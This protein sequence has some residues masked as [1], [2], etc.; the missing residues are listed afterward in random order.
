[1]AR[2][3]TTELLAPIEI[4]GVWHLRNYFI[5]AEAAEVIDLD[6][7]SM[8]LRRLVSQIEQHHLSVE[9]EYFRIGFIV[10]HYGKRGICIS[11]WHW[12]KWLASHELFNQRWYTY[13]RDLTCLEFLDEKEPV[14]CQ[15]EVPVLLRE[16]ELFHKVASEG[17]ERNG[18]DLFM[19][20]RPSL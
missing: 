13:G 11:I 16:F 4:D 7:Y 20:F 2:Q 1:M 15:F 19:Q 9:F 10:G 17:F 3:R 5:R 8:H 14:F 6:L 18:R 12:G